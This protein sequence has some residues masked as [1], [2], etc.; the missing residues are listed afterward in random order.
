MVFV[1]VGSLTEDCWARLMMLGIRYFVS[2]ISNQTYLM[3]L[4]LKVKAAA[5]MTA[6]R[7]VMR[8]TGQARFGQ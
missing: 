5:L 2:L 3:E 7:E 4:R 8:V 1:Q 6:A